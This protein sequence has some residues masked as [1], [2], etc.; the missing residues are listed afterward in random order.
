MRQAGAGAPASARQAA[1]RPIMVRCETSTAKPRAASNADRRDDRRVVRREL[2]LGATALAVQVTVSDI[3]EH[4][5]L[6]SPVRPVAVA[7]DAQLLQ[8]VQGPVDG[9]RDGARVD[10]AAALDELRA[11]DVAVGP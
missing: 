5:E 2:P 8:H 6:L 7:E 10:L 3:R 1:Q 4:V 11:G 9:R